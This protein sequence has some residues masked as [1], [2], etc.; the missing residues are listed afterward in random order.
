M[1]SIGYDIYMTTTLQHTAVL[2]LLTIC[3]LH[4]ATAFYGQPA[5]PLTGCS[6]APARSTST[7][8]FTSNHICGTKVLKIIDIFFFIAIE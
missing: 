5:A 4:L 2:C 7:N 8:L 6:T 3:S 1:D